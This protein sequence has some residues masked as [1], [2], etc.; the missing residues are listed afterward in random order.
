MFILY[1]LFQSLLTSSM[2]LLDTPAKIT[3][4]LPASFTQTSCIGNISFS[5]VHLLRPDVLVSGRDPVFGSSPF[6][7]QHSGCGQRGRNIVLP[8]DSL[9]QA[10]TVQ[11]S[12]GLCNL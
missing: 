1:D 6:S 4:V 11:L 8:V 3:V 5:Q 12:E 7:I 9:V 10:Q 2:K